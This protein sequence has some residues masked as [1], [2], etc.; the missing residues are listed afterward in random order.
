MRR[1]AGAR[2]SALRAR[3]LAEVLRVLYPEGG[4]EATGQVEFLVIPDQRRPRLLV[5]VG[6]GRVAAAAVRRY[7]EP[8]SRLARIKRDAVVASLRTGTA[9]LLLRS[10]VCVPVTSDTIE[11]YLRR[12]LGTD[13]TLSVHIGP[14]RANRKPVLQLLDADATTL[15][16]AKLGV[17]PLTRTLVRAETTALDLLAHRR[18]TTVSVPQVRHAGQ[19]RGHEVLVQSPLPIWEPRVP[20]G[21]DR[22][23]SAM[24]EVANLDG[25]GEA[26]LEDGPYW[27]HLR[28]RLDAIA[29]HPDGRVLADAAHDLVDRVG[30][31]PLR[32]G[33]WHG[34]WA[35]WNM[36]ALADRL[37]LWDWERFAAG[38]PMGFDALH[39]AMQRDLQAGSFSTARASEAV[40]SCVD[41][42]AELLQPF[43]VT[44]RFAAHV[45]AL[46]Y[47]IDLATR[48]VTDRQAEAGARLGA[49]GTWLL[50]ALIRRVSAVE[51]PEVVR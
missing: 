26:T 17:G 45:T 51:H 13:L 15:G 48:Y 28:E 47:L 27:P 38:V 3:Y 39:Y 9:R 42:A 8:Q 1:T 44:D 31:T 36:A 16:F 7:A 30:L 33:C 35:P 34:D 22:L 41:R 29:A 21:G 10:R 40:E 18:L 2:D 11:T 12:A 46:L 25:V 6:S 23:E 24:S 19:W 49:L 20:L 14:A 50:P 37:L 32:Y 43:S 5:P 4:Q